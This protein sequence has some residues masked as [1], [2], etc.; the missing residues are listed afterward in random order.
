[1]TVSIQQITTPVTRAETLAL[2]IDELESLGFTVTAWQDGSPQ[3]TLF[4]VFSL[5]VADLTEVVKQICEFGFSE[6]SSGAALREIS[7]NQFDNTKIEATTDSWTERLT[8]TATVP[9]T[10]LPGQLRI[11]T[12]S[13][14]EYVNT[15]GGTL[16]AGGTLP[17]T[18]VAVTA[19]QVAVGDGQ[20]TRLLTPLAGVTC[21]NITHLVVGNDAETDAALK[22]RNR[23]KWARLSVEMVA[24]A[25]INIALNASTSVRKA[26]VEDNNPRGAG[27]INVYIAGA[28]GDV[29]V[30]TVATVQDVFATH[31]FQTDTAAALNTTTTRVLVKAADEQ[32]LA[33]TGTVYYDAAVALTTITGRVEG[34]LNA[35]IAGLP[36]GGLSY[37]PPGNLVPKNEI[38]NAIRSVEGVRT[39]V[40]SV[41]SAD[42]AV[43]SF[44][45]VAP[46]A[47]WSTLTYQAL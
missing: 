15:T 41:P 19:G 27:T 5:V 46:P 42:V 30:P 21:T 3:K 31:A 6:L 29:D 14:V 40:L 4:A 43:A 22:L 38:E 23:T 39:V 9:Y 1:M 33:V 7:R 18:I 11:A 25:Y 36:I 26:A 12:A 47:D 24:D 34:A 20:I 17:L 13:G 10:I 8:S 44:A 32:A 16:T 45:V 28:A 2:M 35:F 37:P